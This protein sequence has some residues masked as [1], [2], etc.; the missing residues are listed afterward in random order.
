M[1]VLEAEAANRSEML[2]E[3]S[4]TEKVPN[5]FVNNGAI[6]DFFSRDECLLSSRQPSSTHFDQ[7]FQSQGRW[8]GPSRGHVTP[9]PGVCTVSL[10]SGSRTEIWR[11][12]CRHLEVFHPFFHRTQCPGPHHYTQAG[13]QS[14]PVGRESKG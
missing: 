7:C 5:E 10:F 2:T 1:Y 11:F 6:S 9:I 4:L 13:P 14:H 3:V 12:W 8:R